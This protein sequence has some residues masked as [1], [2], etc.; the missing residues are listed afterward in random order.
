MKDKSALP[1]VLLLRRRTGAVNNDT[2]GVY[3][4]TIPVASQG[5]ITRHTEAE[6]QHFAGIEVGELVGEKEI[7]P[8]KT[9]TVSTPSPFQSPLMGRS[10]AVPKRKLTSATPVLLLLRR[11]NWPGGGAEDADRVHAVTVPVTR[12]R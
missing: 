3:A 2:N 8:R 9:P 4:I 11:K 1:E 12:H 5:Q 7:P 10:P 6:A